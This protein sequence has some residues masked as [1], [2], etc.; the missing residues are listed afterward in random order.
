MGLLPSPTLVLRAVLL[1]SFYL[2]L[3]ALK[4]SCLALRRLKVFKTAYPTPLTGCPGVSVII[5]HHDD[6]EMLKE[7]LASVIEAARQVTE[8]VEVL[9]VANGANAAR[10]AELERQ[11]P[12]VRWFFFSGLL[13]FAGA[14][15]CGLENARFE[16]VYLL[17]DDMV[18]DRWALVE[19]LKCRGRFTFAV[20]S[21]IFVHHSSQPGEETGYTFYR[22]VNGII[23]V[24]HRIPNEPALREK[25]LYAGGG[26]SLFHRG[27]LI[28][29]MGRSDPYRP[30]YF[31]DAE[32]SVL[33][34]KHG[35]EVIVC[36]ESHVRHR[37][38]VTH[39][40]LFGTREI[41]RMFERNACRF[42]LRN[43]LHGGS[44]RKLC[45]RLL[46]LEA[47]SF[48][49]V[50]ALR[51]LIEVL[52]A[53]ARGYTFRYPLLGPEG[54]LP[55]FEHWVLF[56]RLLN[57]WF[58]ETKLITLEVL[59]AAVRWP[60]FL[61]A[62]FQSVRN[63]LIVILCACKRKFRLF[64]VRSLVAVPRVADRLACALQCLKFLT[65]K[66]PTYRAYRQGVSVVIPERGNPLLLGDCLRSVRD[67]AANVS[68][69]LEVI[70]VVNG[71]PC[72][73]YNELVEHH[74]QVKWL[75]FERPLWF[76]GAVKRGLKLAQHDWVYL[77]NDD[78]V[79]DPLALREALKW[80]AQHVFAV[81]SQIY[82]KDPHRRREET[83]WTQFRWLR[84]GSFEIFDAEP[85][86]PQVV[87][88]SFY[89][90]GGSSLF[91]RCLLQ[92]FMGSWDAFHPFYWEDVEWGT[93]AWK[94]GFEV[95]FC[96]A[97]K[98]WHSHRATYNQL[99]AEAEIQRVFNRNGHRFQLRNLVPGPSVAAQAVISQLLILEW[100]S[101]A[102]LIRPSVLMGIVQS[103]LRSH[104]YP[105]NEMSLEHVWTKYY[106][107]SFDAGSNKPLVILVSPFAL[108]PPAHGGAVRL[109]HLISVLS[110]RF[111]FV[112]LTDEGD[113]YNRD[114]W[115][116]CQPLG[117]LHLVTGRKEPSEP[118]E[119]R[120]Q[121]ILS[122]SRPELQQQLRLLSVCYHPALV[123][124]EFIELAKL[125]EVRA[126]SAPWV[127][128]LHDVF[129]DED[130]A[131]RS[132]ED[133]YELGLI[134]RFDATVAC[135]YP[136][137]ALLNLPQ[138]TVIPNGVDVTGLRNYCP[139]QG[140]ALLFVGPF[141]YT[142]NLRGIELFLERV[143]PRLLEKVVNLELWIL[144]GRRGAE[145][146]ADRSCFRQPGVTVFDYTE[147]PSYY[148][149]RCAVTL[150]PAWGIRGSSLK[151]LESAAAGRVCVSTAEG[152]RGFLEQSWSS[153]VTVER[154]EDMQRPLEHL[155]LDPV[156]RHSIERLP[157]EALE[158][159]TWKH[160]GKLLGKLYEQLMKG[161]RPSEV[162]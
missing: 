27:R 132:E 67:A 9:V 64:L 60:K 114:S 126:N 82:F 101:L 98:V 100:R 73:D 70:V 42:Q 74:P 112:I 129:L 122:H 103:R 38:R 79:L 152:A 72:R 71:S 137:A 7:C 59:R 45:L 40:L 51:Q 110:D 109:H 8:P 154:V 28:E 142:P 113:V 65:A 90:G 23:E 43:A 39:Q 128:T 93:L 87:R 56:S 83:G 147:R 75:F 48:R 133:Q 105:F 146:A 139:S 95:L 49:E 6:L 3:T 94:Q 156:Y 20:A 157:E 131:Q 26:S 50:C 13:E 96:P 138:V 53:R 121:R 134:R 19:V 111:R 44:D 153:L 35:Y 162:V 24:D 63:S 118:V 144:A 135:S 16:W 151:L 33:A 78:M 1:G 149:E 17:N 29:F 158:A 116:Y 68:E 89:A 107:Q 54:G 58:G 25:I 12:S 124:I 141:R 47:K 115:K 91:R 117:S 155:L 69:P 21:Q 37:H 32:W 104:R 99:F 55:P 52:R 66:L 18:V 61:A 108:Y 97:S 11:F 5:P 130:S 41:D 15:R 22:V 160:S 140:N 57:A 119:G 76:C 84:E 150:N 30:C 2:I 148:L 81:A 145:I 143:Y 4:V 106:F 127:V 123:Q 10:Y 92:R 80:R 102:E 125:I 77:L 159:H 31:E 120:I 161:P 36:A 86:G 46:G 85:E 88:G 62:A 136:D 34:W 14:V